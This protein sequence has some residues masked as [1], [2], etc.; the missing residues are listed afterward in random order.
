MKIIID[1]IYKVPYN[2]KQTQGAVQDQK[3]TLWE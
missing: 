1:W 3:K 2:E